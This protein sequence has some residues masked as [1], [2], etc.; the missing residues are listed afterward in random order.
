MV[1]ILAFGAHP[2][3]VEFGCGAILAKMAKEGKSVAIVDL[4]CGDKGTNGTVEIRK[5]EGEKAAAVIGAT[6]EFLQFRD[7]EVQDSYEGRL[8]IVRVIRTYRPKLVIA[9][10]CIG[11][12]NHPD[13]IACGKLVRAA[14]RYANFKNILPQINTHKC[15]GVLHYPGPCDDKVNFIIDVTPYYD[16]WKEMMGAHQ[17]QFKTFD[18]IDWNVKRAARLGVMIQVPFAQGLIALNPVIVDDVMTICR[19]SKEL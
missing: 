11:E 6:R 4:T 14:V 12:Q 13:H 9:P 7:C 8:E 15:E 19:G 10:I 16:L 5:K 18:Y 3:D 2:D 17:S 1:D